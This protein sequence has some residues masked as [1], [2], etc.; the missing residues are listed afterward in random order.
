[1]TP[2]MHVFKTLAL[3]FLATV[4]LTVIVAD[5]QATWLVEGKAPETIEVVTASPHTSIVLT[6]PAKKLEIQC[7]ELSSSNIKPGATTEGEVEYKNCVTITPIGSGKVLASCKPFEPIKA[8]FKA[9]VFAH[10]SKNYL[11]FEPKIAGKPFATIGFP[12]SCAL[13]ETS[14]VKGSLVAECGHLTEKAFEGYGCS[15]E[16]P[17]GLLQPNGVLFT[18]D[19]LTYG[20]NSAATLSGIAKLIV[21][22]IE[23]EEPGKELT[24]NATIETSAASTLAFV[25]KANLEIQCKKLEGNGLKLLAKTTTGE[26][27]VKFSECKSF[28]PPGSGKV[29][30]AC[31][32]QNEPIV[33]AGKA[34][35]V[36]HSGKNYFLIQPVTGEKVFAQVEFS[37]SC[38]LSQVISI[39]GSL[40]AEC[41]DLK[42]AETWINLDCR[43][44][45]VTHLLRPASTSLFPADTL[46]FFGG[47]AALT[48]E[49]SVKLGSP[50]L[51]KT[52]S[53]H[54]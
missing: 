30:P 40:V 10:S 7:A 13:T 48:G 12:E 31:D 8:S 26:G 47:S 16:E 41:G 44:G 17:A 52:W 18:E 33:A 37:E 24:E 36:E 32:P 43:Y 51:G 34:T 19:K 29:N 23:F 28:S 46:Q 42:P 21:K 25:S 50:L 11:L 45:E 2:T 49:A 3:S 1:M 38:A 39:S 4:G 27:Q 54:V 53:G 14:D 22:E 35:T 9:K 15:L 20:L 5:A 6:V